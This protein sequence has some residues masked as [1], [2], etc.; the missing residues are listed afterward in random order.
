ME[1]PTLTQIVFYSCAGLAVLSALVVILHPNAVRSALF[2]VLTLFAVAVLYVLLNAQFIAAVQVI[3]YAGAVMVLFLFVIMLL[4]AGQTLE[5]FKKPVRKII[6]GIFGLIMLGHIM[7]IAWVATVINAK[8]NPDTM[9][10]QD[11]V[12]QAG[13]SELLGMALFSKYIY[14]FEAISVLLLMAIIGSVILAKRKL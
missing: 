8:P 11:M 13:H 2:L 7:S 14:P 6:G 10:T 1:M 4:N 5:G 12:A 9:A 3:V